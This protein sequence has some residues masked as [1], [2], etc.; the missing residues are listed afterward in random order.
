MND[1]VLTDIQTGF[2]FFNALTFESDRGCALVA[3]AHLDERLGTLLSRSMVSDQAS[4]RLLQDRGPLATFAA[5]IDLAH[6]LGLIGPDVRHDFHIVRK[7]R[8]AFA[9]ELKTHTFETAEIVARCETLTSPRG[10]ETTMAPTARNRFIAAAAILQS[11]IEVRLMSLRRPSGPA[12]TRPNPR[13]C[14]YQTFCHLEPDSC[15]G[16][17]RA[18]WTT[19]RREQREMS[20]SA[21][22]LRQHGRRTRMPSL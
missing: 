11:V 22:G 1:D 13:F 20:F 2:E 12:T 16:W 15:G 8:N 9:H 6:A 5:R 19:S 3:A 4:Q 14:S 21:V 10:I 18:N 17:L 7:V